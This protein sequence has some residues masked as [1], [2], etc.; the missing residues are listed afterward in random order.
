MAQITGGTGNDTLIGGTGNDTVDGGSGY[1]TYVVK[2]SADA[3]YWSVNANGQVILTDAVT[4]PGDAIDGSNEGVDTLKNIQAIEYCR[5]DGTTESTFQ[6][7]DYSNAIDAG[8]YR[9]QYGVWVN[10]RANFYGDLDYFKLDTV[11]GQKVLLSGSSGT[12]YGYLASAASIY[13]VQGQNTDT[14]SNSDKTLTWNATGTYDVYWRSEG[15]S[16]S[17]P[18]ASKG[19]GFIF[20]RELGGTDT[21]DNLTAGDNYEYL[22]GGLGNDTLTGSDRSDSLVGGDGDDQFTG[23]AGNDEIDG[24]AGT[25]NVA[26]YSGNKADYSVTWTGYQNLG[27]TVADKVAGRD[28]TD[29]LTNTQI[30]RFADGD[31]VLDAEPN[32]AATG[33]SAVATGTGF[34]GSL[35]IVKVQ[36]PGRDVDLDYYQQRFT[37]DIS[38]GTAL[39]L[40]ITTNASQS[41]SG[42]GYLSFNFQGTSDALTFTDLINGG[43][44]NQFSFGLNQGAN[45]TS[46]MLSPL[47]WGSSTDFLA[48]AQR[49]DVKVWSWAYDN[50][51]TASLGSKVAYTIRLDRV[52][53]GTAAGDTLTG[54]DVSGYIDALAGNDRVI[55][56]DLG[57]QIVGGLGDDKLEGGGGDD[58]LSDSAGLNR[59]LGDAGNDV[60]NL[61]G[62]ATPTS[63]VQG[64]DGVDTLK[65]ASDTSWTGLSVSGVEVLDGNGGRTSLT[66]AQAQAMGFTTAQNITFRLAP[67]A[68]SGSV[69]DASG[70]QGALSLRGSN[71]SDVLTGNNDNNTFYLSSD[72]SGG[73]G[74]GLDTV[75]AGGGD[76]TIVLQTNYWRSWNQFFTSADAAT[77]TYRLAGQLDGGTGQDKLELNFTEI[78]YTN[79][80]WT[81]YFYQDTTGWKLNLADLS[82][83]SI[84]RLVM[85]GDAQTSNLYPSELVLTAAQLQSISS[86]SGLPAVAIT[87]GGAVDLGHLSGL[88]LNAWRLADG[89]SYQ[90]TGT[91][92]ADVVSVGAGL[93]QVALGEG[94]DE[95]VIEGKALVQDVLDGG[96]GSD[97]LTL[98]GTDVDLS[99]ATLTGIET[100]KVSSQS[101]SM[102]A[103]QWQ[104][105]GDKVQKTSGA[106]TAFILSVSE[107][108]TVSLQ[109]D[110][111]YL[112]LTGSAG[113]DQ[114]LGNAA[115][116]ILVGGAGSDVLNG[117][118]G[119]DRLVS[120]AGLDNIQGGDG[121][122]VLTISDKTLVRDVIAGG[123]GK[124]V[125]KVS[126]GQDLSLAS[127][128]GM[129]VLQVSGTVT[130]TVDQV[131]SFS[132]ISGG[133]VQLAG[134]AST[135]ALSP[136]LR[137]TQGARVLLPAVDATATASSGLV[138]SKG[139]DV[140]SGNA[141]D[142]AIYG[143]RGSDFLSGGA[144]DDTLVGASGTDTLIGG[145]GNDVFMSEASERT[146]G[147]TTYF[148]D[149]ID[150]GSGQDSFRIELTPGITDQSWQT[151]V[152]A[153]G[154][155][156]NVEELV[157]SNGYFSTVSID[158]QTWSGLS[159]FIAS[160]NNSNAYYMP[161]L[162]I[163][164]SG[165]DI[166]FDAV[167]AGSKISKVT[168]TGDF[169][170]IDARNLS[171]AVT[172]TAY[173]RIHVSQLDSIALSSSSDWLVVNGD[174]QFDA[175]AGSGDD[176]IQITGIQKLSGT[177]NGG[178]GNDVLDVSSISIVDMTQT[179]L[180]GVESIY[181]G[182][183]R[184]V[185]TQAQ[186]DAWSFDGTGAKYTKTGSTI[187]GTAAADSYSGD[188]TGAFKGGQGNDNLSQ[189]NTAVF[190]GNYAEYDFTRSGTTLTVQQS[191]GD[192]LDGTDTVSQ[193]MNLKFADTTLVID[194]QPDS[195]SLFRAD[196][197]YASLTN[198]AYDKRMSAKKDYANDVDVFASTLAPSSPLAIEASS[199]NGG[200]LQ[201][202]FIDKSTGQQLSFKS[203]V[204]GNIY[205]TYYS[206]MQASDK[207]LPGFNT[208]DGFKAYAGGDVIVQTNINSDANVNKGITDYAFTLKFLDDYAGSVDTLGA[209]DAQLGQ[210]KGYVGEL[211]DADWV[212]TSLIAGTK[213]EFKLQG[214]SSGGGT[215]L[216]P[217][218]VL[219]DSAGRAIESGFDLAANATGFDDTLVFRPSTTGTYY[220]AVSD[221]AALATGSWTLSQQSLDTIAGNTST[222]ERIT[223]SGA[224][225][226]T[227]SS[228]IN[229]LS[230]HDWFKVWL[231]KGI[232][233]NLRALGASQ[234]GTLADPQ[235]SIRSATGILLGQDDNGGGGTEAKLVY[236]APDSG[237]Y[238]LDA[239]ASGNAG[240]GTYILKGSTLAD[241]YANDLQTTGVVQVGTPQQGL[242][243]YNGDSDWL[244]VGLSKG[245]VYVIDLLGDTSDTAQL[246]PLVDP[247]LIVRDK[248]GDIIARYDDFSGSLNSRAYFVPATDGLYHL[249]AK[250]AF[251]YDI[252]A[253]QL[254]VA[255]APADDHANALTTSATALVLGEAKAGEIGI[256]SDRDMFKVTL[257]AG[258]IYQVS[259][260]GLSN[261]DGTLAD[262]F[263][264]VFDSQGHLLDFDNN[265]GQGN[266]AQLYIE[267]QASGNYYI[268]A[269]SN[270]DR[271]MG[272]YQVSVAQRAMPAD[273]APGNVGTTVFIN[274]GDSFSGH[275]LTHHDQDWF[276][277][278][279]EAGK[280]YVFKAQA[281]HSGHGTLAD[282]VLA[283]HAGNGALLQLVDNM[284]IG[285]EPAFVYTPI[286]TGTYYLAVKAADGA[287]DVG[288][289]TLVTRQP[290]DFSNTWAGAQ[291]IALDQVVSGAIQWSD[292]AYGVRAYDSVGLA[293][294][295]DEDWFQFTAAAGQVLSVNVEMALGSTMSR[296][297]VEIVSA[298]QRSMAVA[299]GLETDNGLAVAT[300]KAP[301]AGT[302][303]A[304][305]IDGAGA[306][307]AY[308]LTLTAGDGSDEDA[309]GPL[310]LNFVNQG[311]ILQ[312]QAQ[313][314]VGL[315]GDTDTFTVTLQADH[316]YR[317]ETLAVRDG[318]TAPLGSAQLGLSWLAQGSNTPET[319]AVS[320][321]IATPSLFDATE[322]TASSSGTMTVLVSAVDATQS[323]QYKVRVIDLGTSLSDDR[324][325]RVAD[326]VDATHGVLAGNDNA[327][328][329]I[330]SEDDVDLFAINLS[331]GNIYD[332][333]VKSYADGLGTLAQA[334][335]RLLNSQGQLVT[336]GTFDAATGRNE[337]A[338]S[339]FETGRYFLDVSAAD[340]PGNTGT[341]ALDTRLRGSDE[342][343]D[344]IRADA[345]SGV[346]AGPGR[347][348]TGKIDYAGDHDW[349]RTS[350]TAG[351]IY[352]LDVLANGDG[353]GGTLQD[354]TLRLLDATGQ[355]IAFDDNS[356]AGLDAHLQFTAAQDGDYHLDVGSNGI[357]NGTYTVRVRELYS[358]IA[359]PLKS[360]QWYL[361]ALGLD[362]LN[363]QITG[364]GVKVAVVDEG[365]DTSHPDL[366]NQLDFALDYDTQ[367]DTP[368]G[369]PKYPLLVGPPDNH[370]TPV[371]GIIAA[372]A[373]NETGVAG[374]APD[375][376]LV[377]TRVKWSYEQ[378]TQALG[379][380]WQ[381]D[382]SNNSWGAT[383]PFSDNFNSTTL[384]F[385]YQA[386][387]TGVEDGRDGLGTVF[388]FSAGNSN[389]QGDNTNYHNFQNAR[390]VITVAATDADGS[391]AGFST[392]GASVLVGA[393][394]VN[395]LTTD[396]HQAGWGYEGASNYTSFTGTSAA[397]PVVSG[398]VALMLESNPDLGYRDVQ[399]ILAYSAWHPDNQDWKTNGASNFN[400]GGLQYNDQ[401]GF[402]VVDAYSAVRLAQTWTEQNTAI[403]E[404]SASAR[405][406]GLTDAIPDGDGSSYTRSF[407]IDA[408][409]RIEHVE[410]G[411]DLR[412]TRLGDMVIELVSPNGTVSTLMNRPT[413]NA[414]QPFG[415]SGT[416]SGVPTH[417]L[418]DFSSVQ[419]WGEE[420]AGTWTVR[421]KDVRAEETGTLQ[422]LSLRVYGERD[423]GNDTYVFTD[424][425]FAEPV[426]RV[427]ADESGTDTVNASATHFDVY[428]D[429]GPE[430]VIAANTVSYAI[431]QWSTIENAFTGMGN[432]RLVGNAANN[433]LS[434]MEGNDSLQGAGGND[435]IEGGSGTDTVVY[436][437]KLDEY[438]RSWNPN[439]RTLTVVDL[440][441]G[442][443][444]D[445]SD[446]LTGIERLVF[447]N[448][449]VNLAS[450]VGNRAPVANSSWFDQVIQVSA[451][452]GID[453]DIPNTAFSDAD[454]NSTVT[455]TVADESGNAPPSWLSYDEATGTVTGVPPADYQ[456]QLKLL[457]AATDEFGQ[458]A[459]DVLTLQFGDN[460][461]PVLEAAREWT[462]AEDAGQQALGIALPV[463]PEDKAI[464]ITIDELPA[465]GKVLDKTGGLVRV[466]DTM[467]A[468]ELTELFY[469]S[470]KDDFGVMGT[471]R[472][473]AVD[474]DLVQASSSVRIIVT[475]SNDAPRFSRPD[476]TL[477]VTFPLSSAAALDLAI[478]SDPETT[479]TGVTLSALPALG[480]VWLG[481]TQVQL[482]QSLSLAQLQQL[483]FTLGENVRGP[484]GAITV[485]ATDGQGLST[486]W[487]LNLEVSGDAVANTGSLAAD[488]L[489]GSIG[490]DTLYGMAGDDLLVGNAGNDRLLGGLGNDSLFGGSGN[491]TLDGSS[492]NDLLDGGIG[493]DQMSGGPGADTYFV[494]NANDVVLEAIA[495]GT[496]G[497]DLVIT[498]ISLAAPTNVENLQAADG[499]A[500]DLS[501]NTL[502][503]ALVGNALNNQLAGGDG[504]D[505][506]F[507]GG[508]NDTLDGGA[509]VDKLVGG[510]GDDVYHVDSRLDAI[511]ELASEGTDTVW[512][513]SHYTLASQ[514]E[515][516][517]LREGGDWAASG[518]SLNNHIVGNFGHNVLA[519]GMGQDTLEGGLGDDIYVLNDRGDVIIDTGGN[520]TIRTSLD[521]SL[522]EG[523]E[524]LLLVGITDATGL[525]N[526]AA[527][528]ITG[529]V[530]DNILDGGAGLDTLTG[531]AG[532]DQFVLARNAAGLGADQVTDF[533]SGTDLL[534]IDL[535]SYGVDVQGLGLPSSGTVQVSAFV[536]GAGAVALDNNDHFVLD[537]AQG[538]LRFDPDGN[539]NQ[540]AMDLVKLV[541]TLDSAFNGGDIYLAI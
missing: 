97:T 410:L 111:A 202:A 512:A 498:Q 257:Q 311:N 240:K 224:E 485:T 434:G 341:F 480:K 486:S 9:I 460:Q 442:D 367:F 452:M 538:I 106:N 417:L 518:N 536:K 371:A 407:S 471:L 181:H 492:G 443:G 68:A 254:R 22:V 378:I 540:A 83:T 168:L 346:S 206:W 258:N 421:V 448:G 514:L 41:V 101:L 285:N 356:G 222:T 234:G 146:A 525:G 3:Y 487:S 87:G 235:L 64:G 94:N 400:L 266:D 128:S 473:T 233:Y 121:N 27:L 385:A 165:T 494:D 399:K 207:W 30:L 259:V 440:V 161:W 194:D 199:G 535:L 347:T 526:S 243:S 131:A 140:I 32:V 484:I 225:T 333:S 149:R 430:H 110:S 391:V 496:G 474:Q 262:P 329:R 360:A 388:V 241:D 482:G 469:Q 1:N 515:H 375:A 188:G 315:A 253:Y 475:A 11:S 162:A 354:A 244:K 291:A 369:Q 408:N 501:G 159:S 445:G 154:S 134:S 392:P 56:S 348:A 141:G 461:A 143:G 231:D 189:L 295:S 449:D 349:I 52:V 136:D 390:E 386:L 428:V 418:W 205:G 183:S 476:A 38:A 288:S 383:S 534:V 61:S 151:F 510:A 261:H 317:L 438:S 294:D 373:N 423:D 302:Y 103:N 200:H 237:W 489:Y 78:Y 522:P 82:W 191:R 219:M 144:G 340:L 45:E 10:G 31:V 359:D 325:N 81:T 297:M 424:E 93:N 287:N 290:D 416:D 444:N 88:G 21:A 422:S 108:G 55:G 214:V 208:A 352:V 319:I 63:T 497:K 450:T 363:G 19:Y 163:T 137:L 425:G 74:A 132:E 77:H 203:L 382:V 384:T 17:T 2:G 147:S 91:A 251:K 274:P 248:N 177:I 37:S 272:S 344:D 495:G 267:A 169:K 503:N 170:S 491:D 516:L 217:K 72:E 54:D 439:T 198:A 122:D 5:P 507:G 113:D 105:L 339:V 238:Y 13:G 129:E 409:M 298:S 406:F 377:S 70:L 323:G 286:S 60:F 40:T 20:R 405:K 34:T 394:G 69:L 313:A 420:A 152:I 499:A 39:R 433:R 393:Y 278:R 166:D 509:G 195:W 270:K 187:V 328:G 401:A 435:Q 310:A 256:P 264:R 260:N 62:T 273:E 362:E 304:R 502:D 155:L 57:E 379:L 332:F 120:G 462:V 318:A 23:G 432:D 403:N 216:D 178:I 229:A 470:D 334:Q 281:S 138:G 293:T 245:Q 426:S 271:A 441:S 46:W 150:G 308:T 59:L 242:I 437:G 14:S 389:A 109:A 179:V 493:N 504:R 100:I 201:F 479:L 415:L 172:P 236:S 116:N 532:S 472:Y 365:I 126:D 398:V 49:A 265:G 277:I 451:G 53:L 80:A 8:N 158:N 182:S 213:Y 364:A 44:R 75:M 429:L 119:D 330:D 331:V 414:E 513:S 361:A 95:I 413:V 220:L 173:F 185:L 117:Y 268:E 467:T 316:H 167:Q 156:T 337:L 71:Q 65:V 419:F 481:G 468:D 175:D 366:Q 306:S 299:D 466:G 533:V 505:S 193:V 343:T 374:I 130:L 218:L 4:D 320:G 376:E 228:E 431:A 342:R 115:N 465:R 301:E 508:G 446:T 85:L 314:R 176:R 279:L 300:F 196:A 12:G 246:D 511:Q 230:D 255:L 171:L 327:N 145:A 102:S 520:D 370:G 124:D 353:G 458:T 305:V 186:F 483:S 76:D 490:A 530:G 84:E 322:Y 456:G 276:G 215:L 123:S 292:G 249:E 312:A 180:A 232:T 387:R 209:M 539:G 36:D 307:G 412:H 184:L 212:R 397:A 427:L 252:G 164:G 250:S 336:T 477:S 227:V 51:N 521:T 99:G 338:V 73:S 488:A 135:F 463:D 7:D 324:P 345:Q 411:V 67:A 372:Q 139:D 90:I 174:T 454:T 48:T 96:N 239:G 335:L 269:S 263:V 192:M 148:S 18:T 517:F 500:V 350:M 541:G 296:P 26:I 6:L 464:T 104:S 15:L 210:V 197:G 25:A 226:F 457:I 351:K 221:V 43:T 355:E 86:T 153:A 16:S 42:T 396:R 537:T 404:T 98:R 528:Q 190:S 280:N 79:S 35:P 118:A 223:W 459:S 527:N 107:P 358:G 125:L 478:P 211:G 47:R 89:A 519:G 133:T 157:V 395:L 33:L 303:Y 506:L 368:D 326:Y 447:A 92:G 204:N 436:A 524:N 455:M 127:I 289:Y 24:G 114:L 453:F 321:T 531:G 142:D 381:F 283:L 282:P 66:P 160:S 284:L 523:I 29:L 50:T 58:V 112:G 247:L 309:Q 28:G 357:Q 529:N 275:L 402:G 380:Q